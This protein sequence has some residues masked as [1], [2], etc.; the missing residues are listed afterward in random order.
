VVSEALDFSSDADLDIVLNKFNIKDVKSISEM[1]VSRNTN[2]LAIEVGAKHGL[3]TFEAHKHIF[4][5]TWTHSPEYYISGGDINGK[6]MLKNHELLRKLKVNIGSKFLVTTSVMLGQVFSFIFK[7]YFKTI[8]NLTAPP[9]VEEK[10]LTSFQLRL[11]EKGITTENVEDDEESDG[12]ETDDSQLSLYSY[13]KRY[14]IKEI[15]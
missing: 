14:N 11:K 7:D 13:N 3:K 10:K 4:F 2:L 12:Y 15:P 1:V 9:E 6:N 8:L 5:Y